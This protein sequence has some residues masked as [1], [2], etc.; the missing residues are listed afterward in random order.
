MEEEYGCFE[1]SLQILLDGLKYCQY[2]EG[3]LTKAVKQHERKDDYELARQMLSSLRSEPIDRVWRSILEGALFEVRTG[4]FVAARK[5]FQFL[6]QNVSWYG[7]IYYEA[8]RLD[9]KESQFQSALKIIEKGLTE[10]PRYGPLW[11]G[12]LKI[13]ER[14]DMENEERKWLIGAKPKLKNLRLK[15]TNAVRNISP[16]LIWKIY[17]EQAQAEERAA[18]YASYG[19][20]CTRL[21][22][23]PSTGLGIYSN[24]FNLN[25]NLSSRISSIRNKLYSPSRKSFIRSLL[26]CPNNLKWKIWLAGCRLELSA[27]NVITSRQLLCFA[28]ASV[29]IKSKSYVYLEA[30]RVEEYSGNILAARNIL[31]IARE[32]ISSEWKLF[33]EAVLLEARAGNMIQAIQLAEISLKQHSGTGRLWSVLIQ[34]CHRLETIL[35]IRQQDLR[36]FSRQNFNLLS[37]HDEI[38]SNE[39]NHPTSSTTTT[40]DEEFDDEIYGI[41]SSSPSIHELTLSNKI[42]SINSKESTYKIPNKFIIL[43]KAIKHVPKS[44]EV[45]CEGARCLLNPMN[46]TTFD[47]SK[48]QRYLQFAIQFT[49]QYGDAFIEYL[50]LEM[51]SQVILPCILNA[52][53]IPIKAFIQRVFQCDSDADILEWIQGQSNGQFETKESQPHQQRRQIL[54]ALEKMTTQQGKP[55]GMNGN[56]FPSDSEMLQRFQN[57]AMKKL[58]RR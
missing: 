50:R 44:G 6:M 25:D 43:S 20:C 28:F 57:I 11:F 30:S 58:S 14:Y 36:H 41:L 38:S 4:E 42:K 32:E 8:Y 23:I 5:I 39:S 26:V 54:I 52:L 53:S 55:G 9:E 2:N 40:S 27:G 31:R 16:E 1:K 21:I 22:T 48:A 3:L 33:L 34:L 19:L 35:P 51:I 17:F 12:L 45:W 18:D 56:I 47:L 15:I 7:P 49:P 13:M 46:V 29:P 24:Y 10:L 37:T